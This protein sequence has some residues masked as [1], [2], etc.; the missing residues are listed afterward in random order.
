[1]SGNPFDKLDGQA[2]PPGPPSKSVVPV[3]KAK[4]K[5][6]KVILQY[7]RAGRGGKEVTILKGLWIESQEMRMREAL[8]KELKR[9]LGTGGALEG[10]EI[11]LQGDRRET[12]KAWLLKEGFTTNL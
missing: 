3:A 4:P 2:L 10:R 9:A 6:G 5:L 7:E 1:M 12:A 11:V 8:L